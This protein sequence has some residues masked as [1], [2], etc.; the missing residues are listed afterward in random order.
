M[1]ENASRE[2]VA[3]ATDDAV[4][5]NSASLF[6][7]LAA[8]VS[9][10]VLVTGVGLTI[11]GYSFARM[12]IDEQIAIRFVAEAR[13]RQ[14]LF[15]SLIGRQAERL[16]LFGNDA[17]I[18]RLLDLQAEGLLG[19][20]D[21]AQEMTLIVDDYRR[22]FESTSSKRQGVGGQFLAVHFVNIDDVTVC[23]VGTSVLEEPVTRLA[24]YAEGKSAFTM[25]FPRRIRDAKRTVLAGPIIT[26]NLRR[27]VVV[28][29][30][31]CGPMLH[32]LASPA[33]LGRSGE[34]VVVREVGGAL[35]LL[36]PDQDGQLI[37]RDPA[38]WPLAQDGLRG[39]P[40]FGPAEDRHGRQVLAA[41]QPLGYQ[42]WI[43]IAKMDSD[44]AY[45]PLGRLG[46]LLFGLAGG[47]LAAGIVLSQVFAFRITRPLTMLVHFAGRFAQGHLQERCD[48]ESG[49]E[50]RRL[51]QSLNSMAEEL[52]SSYATLEERVNHRTAQLIETNKALRHEIEVRQ[53][54]EQ[55]FTHERFLLDTLLATLPDNIY[56]KDRTS[57][58]LRIGH[59]MAARFGLAD[60]AEAIG[61]TDFDFFTDTHAVQARQ[62]EVQLMESGD[63]VLRLEEQETWPDG[64]VTW[65]ETT[66]LPLRNAQGE[67]VGTFGIS[68]DI[69]ERKRAEIALVEAK[70][71]ADAA[72]RAKS[73]F[74]ANMSHEIRT[75]LS[76]IL[77]MTELALDT[78]LT[79]EQREY[80]ETV[81]QSAEALLLIVNDILDFSKIEAGKLE[82]ET[83]EFQ[84]LD[85][86][87]NA[88]HTLALRAHAKGL[89]LAY[90]VA[91]EVPAELVGD[92]MRFRQ[93]V[94]NLVGNS[95]KF[96]HEGEVVVRVALTAATELAA[97]QVM[98]QVA[99]TDTGIGIPANKQR[100]IFDAFT[101]ADAS[102]TRRFGGTGLGL[103]ISNYLVQRMGGQIAVESLEGQG[104]TFHFTAVFGRKDR[105]YQE[106]GPVIPENLRG[107]VVLIV[108]DNSTTLQ[109]LRDMLRTW[110][111][112][113][114]AVSSGEA[115]LELLKPS[116]QFSTSLAAA[117]IDGHMPGMDGFTLV[118]QMRREPHGTQ[119]PIVLLTSGNRPDDAEWVKRFGVSSQLAKPVRRRRL[120]QALQ[121]AL[122]GP[123]LAEEASSPRQLRPL[124]TLN[125]LVA[126]DGIVNQKLIRE[127]L[128]KQGHRV[129]IVS[130]G[131]DAVAAWESA[132][133]DI[134]L[135]DVQM[136]GMDGLA[137]TA[138]IR[139][140]ERQTHQRPT[141]IVAMTAHAMKGDRER[142]LEAGMDQYVSKPLRSQLLF[143]VM[144]AALGIVESAEPAAATVPPDSQAAPPM[145]GI[146]DWQDALLAVNGDRATLAS[147][148]EAFM[149]EAPKLTRQLRETL[150]ANDAAAFRRAAHTL[151][152]SLRFFGAHDAAELAWQLEVL[153]KDGDLEAAARQVDLLIAAV[154]SVSQAV[155]SGPI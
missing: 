70:E 39:V 14:N 78:N 133:P 18:I 99:V 84:L 130:G 132:R 24:E 81:S 100:A 15:L 43:L 85:V 32:L 12:I 29:E 155:R 21:F 40:G 149:S 122:G 83:T 25:G 110:G 134:V 115:A 60:P 68:R 147:V 51:A 145:Q 87:D 50:V 72:N 150:E 105:L 97:D 66:K 55:A 9:V 128:V 16:Q 41:V 59:A 73:E 48:L 10:L 135:M 106:S 1:N 56:F 112:A 108:D 22:S 7:R 76:G 107:K 27:F 144:A 93:V 102:T 64:R 92:P 126:E 95:I 13:E 77:G 31:D 154:E 23:T 91:G 89:E 123:A 114:I 19:A 113:P 74:V 143:Q 47:T 138:R 33:N 58:F 17:R 88:L 75:P 136:P 6:T 37:D 2:W 153:G 139:E 127:L 116:G 98:L 109:I 119:L 28:A 63:S 82:L 53:A 49:G 30:L 96:T 69:T 117:V 3:R 94:T 67:V 80:L 45:E 57:R 142:C 103:T 146:V 137:A 141:P 54:A 120:L 148:S 124:P 101:Q 20:D 71:A 5:P 151:K 61:K 46:M 36:D 44:E 125:V 26:E 65:V 8:F 90:E 131:A 11:A 118:Q 38:H 129:R 86:L 4:V 111:L 62:D 34:L 79:P 35:Q 140:L 104:T 42:N 121:S 52:Q 152:S